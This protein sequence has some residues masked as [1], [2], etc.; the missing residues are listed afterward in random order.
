MYNTQRGVTTK[1]KKR[2]AI[3]HLIINSKQYNNDDA[4]SKSINKVLESTL[5]K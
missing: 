3:V 1:E 5:K 2:G 4:Y